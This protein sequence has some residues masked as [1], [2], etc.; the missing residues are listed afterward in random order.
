MSG[1]VGQRLDHFLELDDRA[2]PAMGDDQR[3]RFRMR[4]ADVQEVNAE[5]V[6]LRRELAK[7][8]EQRLAAA[9]IIVLRPIAADVP[10]PAERDALAPVVDEFGLGPARSPQ[11]QSQVVENIIADRD[12]IGLDCIV[13]GR[14]QNPRLSIRSK[15]GSGHA[16]ARQLVRLSPRRGA[17]KQGSPI[18]CLA[19]VQPWKSSLGSPALEVQPWQALRRISAPHV[20]LTM[21]V[22]IGLARGDQYPAR[23][24]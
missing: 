20:Q 8:I 16:P 23:R 3:H 18:H 24:E 12:A 6:D 19:E 1:R 22:Q 2:R 15:R 4:G 11:P 9:P 14:R 17:S 7:A 5:T 21:T 10:D 13:H